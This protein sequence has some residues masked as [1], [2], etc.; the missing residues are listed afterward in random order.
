MDRYEENKKRE[1]E[2]LLRQ[3]KKELLEEYSKLAKKKALTIKQMKQ[4]KE[5]L[6]E[7][8]K[9]AKKKVL[10]TKHMIKEELDNWNN[11]LIEEL[12]I[13]GEIIKIKEGDKEK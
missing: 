4:L 7:Y 11:D 6:E 1:E 3:I 10:K 5:L 8:N 9:L 13:L 2:E 12:C